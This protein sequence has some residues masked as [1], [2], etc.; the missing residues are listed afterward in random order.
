MTAEKTVTAALIIIGNEILSGRTKDANLPHIAE[1]LN[2]VGVRLMEVRVI[3]DIEDEIVAAL[4]ALR[5]KYDYVFTTGGIGPTHDDITAQSVA[6]AFGQKLIRHPE[7]LRRLQ[8]HYREIDL[9]LTE[10][11]LRMANTP[12]HATLIDNPIS[13]APGFQVENVFVMAGVPK[14]MQAMLDNIKGRLK[15]GKP[16]LSRAVHCN[17]GEGIIAA[18]LGAIQKRYPEVDIG[19]YPRFGS[20]GF[21]VSL[22]VRHTD[23]GVLDKVIDE[24]SAL[25]RELGGEPRPDDED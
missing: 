17:L 5:Q 18:G 8:K 21:R 13:T 23:A 3:A 15:G 11:R 22:V 25:I 10:A 2:N 4:N 24:I 16:V 1:V 12:E 19:S 9:E 7:A 6:R 20:S 14:I